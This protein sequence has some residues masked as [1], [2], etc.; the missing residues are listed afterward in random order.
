M[1][2]STFSN[3]VAQC[4][5]LS[6]LSCYSE[7]S[8][9]VGI[10]RIDRS[11]SSY[12]DLTDV[13]VVPGYGFM[14]GR[15]ALT[16]PLVHS[17]PVGENEPHHVHILQLTCFR[18][19][20]GHC[21][22]S[23]VAGTSMVTH[24][25]FVYNWFHSCTFVQRGLFVLA[26]DVGVSAGLQKAPHA[27]QMFTRHSEQQGRLLLQGTFVDWTWMDW[28][29]KYNYHTNQ[30]GDSFSFS[31]MQTMHQTSLRI[32]QCISPHTATHTTQTCQWSTVA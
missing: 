23:L 13:R 12:E 10:R 27:R 3:Q 19:T 9:A 2:K 26:A 8:D 15:P 22:Y 31:R 25:C 11:P 17:G 6:L 16:T 14:E 20:T 32:Y 29:R 28:S 5:H 24:T 21:H 4:P 7:R 18:D 1:Q 30:L